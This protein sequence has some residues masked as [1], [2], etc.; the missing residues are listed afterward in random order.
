MAVADGDHSCYGHE[1]DQD[2]LYDP[3][4]VCSQDVRA[5]GGARTDERMG[6]IPVVCKAATVV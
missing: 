5:G 4:R 6:F 1:D 2:H 3:H